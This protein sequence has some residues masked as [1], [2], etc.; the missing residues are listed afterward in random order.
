MSG[1]VRVIPDS[2][3]TLAE[4][5][6]ETQWPPVDTQVHKLDGL[7]NTQ[8]A[9]DN[10]NANAE[11]LAGY[12]RM[13]DQQNRKLNEMLRITAGEYREVDAKYA[14]RINSEERAGAV[15]AIAAPEPGTPVSPVP[16]LARFAPLSAGGYSDVE[17]TQ[18]ALL[19]GDH[20]AS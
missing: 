11:T 15:D 18:L 7:P 5:R 8:S 13:A 6:S 16:D 10:L 4:L 14:D 12:Q 20:G 1:G 17:Q 2:L 19:D 9:V 3:D